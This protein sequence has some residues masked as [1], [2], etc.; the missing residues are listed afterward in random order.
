[1]ATGSRT[2]KLSILADIDDLKKKLDAGSKEVETFG[3]KVTGFGKAAA[4][5][6]AAAAVAAGAYAT[7]LAVDGVKSALED[8]QAQLRLA[9]ALKTATGATAAQVKAT[10]D[11]I[12]KTQLAYGI[13]DDELRPALQRLAIAT[14]SVEK[15]QS[16]LNLSL[17]VAKGTNKPLIDVVDA[18]GK[19]YEG[20]TKSLGALGIGITK[21]ELQTMNFQQVQ[22]QLSDLYGG[23]ATRNAETFQGRIDRLTQA[24]NEAKENVG[25]FLLPIIDKLITYLIQYGTPIVEKF[26]DAW[27]VISDAIERN[28]E[29]FEAFGQLLIDYVFPAVSKV[30]GFLV[31][32]GAK[33]ATAIINAFG[34]IAGAVTPVINFIIDAINKVITGINLIKPGADIGYISKIGTS[35]GSSFTYGAGNPQYQEQT[36]PAIVLPS[37][38]TNVP[39][40]V[41]GGAVAAGSA[42]SKT[43]KFD[44]AAYDMAT[45]MDYG[46]RATTAEALRSGIL[47]S[48][49]NITINGAIDSEGTARQIANILTQSDGRGGTIYFPGML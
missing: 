21:A 45:I 18:L 29:K 43:T 32:V 20:N 19:A 28:R 34:T 2:L 26:R 4:V 11:Y 39:S 42:A 49:V 44:Q 31:D 3:D 23:A 7:K 10:E 1:M 41:S 6:F 48:A 16:L 33:A 25:T 37:G 46:A 24:F 35:G 27:A 15:S 22:K 47:P 8:E 9:S 17:D 30:F 36:T 12:S 13:A 5:A 40:I 14:G 38:T